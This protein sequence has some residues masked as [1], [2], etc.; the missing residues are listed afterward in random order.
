MP[1]I[2]PLY[3]GLRYTRAKRRNQ[4][5]SFVSAF[6]LVGMALGV[7]ALIAVLS[8]MNGFDREMKARILSVVPHGFIDREP[9]LDD[10]QT[11]AA[12]VD[13]HPEV[14]ASAPYIEGF[15]LVTHARG[16][17]GVQILGVEPEAQAR[18][19]VVEQR[20][21]L[22]STD[23]LVAGEFR[24]VMGRLLARQL[25][26]ALGDKVRVTLPDI[27][28]TPAGIF[29]R[30]RRFTLVGVFEVGAQMDQ[31][32]AMI[33]LDDARRLFRVEGVQGLQLQVSDIYR[34]APVLSDLASELG[35]DYRVRDW[36]QTQG[37]LFQAVK[38]EK[39][40]IAVLLGIIIAVA[41][42]NIVSSLVL[43]VADKRSDI[44]VLRTL[45]MSARQI[46]AVFV[47]QGSAVGIAGTA[48]GAVLGCLLAL[49]IGA[50]VASIESLLGL[51]IFDPAVY[52]ISHLP[53]QLMWRDV[54]SICGVALLL[55]FLATLYPAWRAAKIEPAEALRY[56]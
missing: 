40:V 19:S 29:P 24:I 55:S 39:L 51:R 11:L 48:I 21:T 7:M 16:V 42:F 18:V 20:M 8:V 53:S 43:M 34:A 30:V 49:N 37:S 3:I 15:G 35:P 26:L 31:S 32:L 9:E 27:R 17:E 12:K 6:S 44:A 46:M 38:M 23:D 14:M 1:R 28:V 13:Q 45:G 36:S 56:E 41:A 25:G 4:F 22:G 33:H 47:V 2:V 52:F 10:W 50:L 54:V 5:I